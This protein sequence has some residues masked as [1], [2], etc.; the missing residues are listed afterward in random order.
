MHPREKP[1]HL[2]LYWRWGGLVERGQGGKIVLAELPHKLV[3]PDARPPVESN[4]EIEACAFMSR[5]HGSATV[6]ADGARSWR[7]HAKAKRL[8][9]SQVNHSK[10]QFTKPRGPRRKAAGTQVLDRQWK[11]LKQYV[12]REVANKNAQNQCTSPNLLYNVRNKN[13]TYCWLPSGFFSLICTWTC[14]TH[15][16]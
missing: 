16:K 5:I 8:K 15:W 10:M 12:P 6:F 13:L 4:S 3:S 7:A 11:S 9:F 14:K 2:L 1:K